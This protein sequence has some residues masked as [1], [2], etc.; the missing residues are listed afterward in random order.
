MKDI[1]LDNDG[2]PSDEDLD[3]TPK[4]YRHGN[5]RGITQIIRIRNW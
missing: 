3:Q 1:E 2:L 5:R 4:G